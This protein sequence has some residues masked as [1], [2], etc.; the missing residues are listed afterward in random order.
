VSEADRRAT[1]QDS[2]ARRARQEHNWD[3][4]WARWAV[5]GLALAT[6]SEAT[7]L[8][9]GRWWIAVTVNLLC[10]LFMVFYFGHLLLRRL[11]C[12]L[13]EWCAIIILLGNAEALLFTTPGIL[14]SVTFAIPVS[15]L[16]A[17]WVL[18]GSTLGLVQA[19]LLGVEQAAGRLGILLAAWWSLAGW[20]LLLGGALLS[21]WGYGETG[22]RLIGPW[23]GAWRVPLVVAGLCGLLVGWW[24]RSKARKAAKAMICSAIVPAP[25]PDLPSKGD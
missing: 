9:E 8:H 13:L 18:Y 16:I 14:K 23:L 12:S 4:K 15:V 19:R 24:V 20:S 3:L 17:A 5:T 25:R 7:L 11:Q 2:P 6:L 10:G 1:Q 21:A 22:Q